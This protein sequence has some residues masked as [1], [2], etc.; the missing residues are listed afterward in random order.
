M[1]EVGPYA[2]TRAIG[3]LNL[4][5]VF[6]FPLLLIALEEIFFNQRWT[7]KR[8]GTFA[9]V[10]AAI[11]LLCTEE[12]LAV[13]AVGAAFL[14]F[15][16]GVT[17]RSAINR[18]RFRY[19]FRTLPFAGGAFLIIAGFPLFYQ[20][21][22]AGKVHGAIQ[23]AIVYSDDLLSLITPNGSALIQPHFLSGIQATSWTGIGSVEANAYIGIPLLVIA[24]YMAWRWHRDRLVLFA[25]ISAAAM[26]VL[27]LGPHL[28]VA[29]H[30]FR[31]GYLPELVVT[32]IPVL[33]NIL[34]GRFGIGLDLALGLL[35]A[36]FLTRHV[37][38][39]RKIWK[40]I[41]W[42]ALGLAALASWLPEELPATADSTPAY[43]MADGHV[44][45]LPASS[46]ALVLPY[47]DGSSMLWQAQSKFHIKIDEG[48]AITAN[49]QGVG[50]F[51]APGPIVDAYSGIELNGTAPSRTEN[52]RE[53]IMSQLG[54]DQTKTVIVGP[55][56]NQSLAINFT[57]W[58]L[59]FSPTY[60]QG[61]YV[62][63][64]TAKS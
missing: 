29:G 49:K 2:G 5:L 24:G 27:T 52:E 31:H 41:G 21:F 37:F 25:L 11:Q 51:F 45:S 42:G 64:L 9:G 62:W 17:H 39:R 10:A 1:V 18:D 16:V 38:V 6:A 50:V 47:Y 14:L 26:F 28:H 32:H 30:V 43:F 19:V 59:G 60:D 63:S 61:V 23:P 3:H 12:T 13:F 55:M 40:R 33:D 44:N 7:P 53:G 54:E 8:V 20:F 48:L 36:L 46:A 22:G 35:F 56:P 58:L 57:T 4:V 34:P 15:V